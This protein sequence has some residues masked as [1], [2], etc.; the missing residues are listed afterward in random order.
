MLAAFLL[1][2]AVPRHPAGSSA[3]TVVGLQFPDKGECK[4]H[5]CGCG[6][7]DCTTSD[8]C[9]NGCVSDLYDDKCKG[10]KCDGGDMWCDVAC[11]LSADCKY[12][13]EY[14]KATSDCCSKEVSEWV[15]GSG[16]VCTGNPRDSGCCQ[17]R[18][19]NG[20]TCTAHWEC[21]TFKCQ[22]KMFKVH[23]ECS[24]SCENCN[25]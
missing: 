2:F 22:D 15:A 21:Q 11:N 10:C 7:I 23:D 13:G 18:K 9:K 19:A 20:E 8:I 6:G 25:D 24:D 3:D 17:K 12:L 1:C 16:F 5:F 4:C 14:A